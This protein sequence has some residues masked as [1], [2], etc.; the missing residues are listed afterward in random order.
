MAHAYTHVNAACIY[1]CAPARVR[2]CACVFEHVHPRMPLDFS[3][4]HQR[5]FEREHRPKETTASTRDFRA[6]VGREIDPRHIK[7]GTNRII[8]S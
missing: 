8:I 1:V 4:S 6:G 2:A 3:V 7:D 5:P